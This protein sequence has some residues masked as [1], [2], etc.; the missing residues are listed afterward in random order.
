MPFTGHPDGAPD[1]KLR[2]TADDT[3][4]EKTAN[5][6]LTGR[7]C[8]MRKFLKAVL[9]FIGIV[10]LLFIALIGIGLFVDFE[11]DDPIENGRYT[12]VPEE[13][14]YIEFTTGDYDKGDAGLT[15]YDTM[16]E[17]VLHSPLKTE[18]ED[19]SVPDDFLNHVDETLHIWNGTQYDT[20]FY[21]AGTNE[22]PM[23]GFVFARL[24]KRVQNGHTQYAY[25]NS[26][27]D[28]STPDS[29]YETDSTWIH[30]QLTVSDIQQDL[31]PHY[32]DT[33]FV[34]GYSHVPEIYTLE[35]EGQ[36]PD[37]II[38]INVYDKMMYLWYY[39]DLKSNKR[40]DCLS[41][42]IDVPQ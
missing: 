38:E 42:S 8:A 5:P 32:P 3:G 21:R 34:F 24:K 11:Y 17:A 10:F 18:N 39:N 23:Q 12:Y 37:G 9:V 31:N 22:S 33:R 36:K 16:E 27:Q 35:I 1:A 7:C 28:I 29:S 15:Y 19:L 6:N 40:G 41:Y 30:L 26:T 25:I 14:A 20:I 4:K 13:N 2:I